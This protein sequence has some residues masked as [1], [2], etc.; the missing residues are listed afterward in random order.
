MDRLEGALAR[1]AEA[2]AHTEEGVGRLEAAILRLAEAQ[3]RTEE[4]LGALAEAQA[5]TEQRVGRLEA[6]LEK[7]A[8]AQRRTEEA[9]RQ[10]AQAV[11]RLSDTVGYGL[12]D[13]AKVV[14]PGYLERHLGI[15]LSGELGEELKRQW[16]GPEGSEVEINLYGEGEQEGQ[17]VVVL[18]EA[19]SR[20]YG[21]EVE[22]FDRAI[23]PIAGIL[24]EKV[25]KVMVG[26]L[27]HPSASRLAAER[28]ILLVA[29]YQ[30]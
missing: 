7:L 18:G 10:L 25:V 13:V 23:Q 4:R 24:K 29:S 20:I 21:R 17:R 15:R 28:D 2:Q 1:L 14:L 16:I 30:R 8:E 26:Y 27:I 22:Q 9:V 12:E 19:K 5:R 6:A 11:G 3:A